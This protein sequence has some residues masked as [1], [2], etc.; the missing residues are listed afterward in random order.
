VYK[1]VKEEKFS[2]HVPSINMPTS[3]VQTLDPMYLGEPKGLRAC[4]NKGGDS[5]RASIVK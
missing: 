4:P 3:R 1:K 5:V 2:R